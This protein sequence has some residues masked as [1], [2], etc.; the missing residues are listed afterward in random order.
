MASTLIVLAHFTVIVNT[1]TGRNLMTDLP[2]GVWQWKAG[3]AKSP[4]EFHLIA[5]DPGAMATGWAH[6]V[7]DY[8]AFSRPENKV[9]ANLKSWDCGQYTGPDHEQYTAAQMLVYRARYDWKHGGQRQA[10]EFNA[11]TEVVS[12]DFQLVQ[13]IG[14]KNL[15]APVRFNAVL[16]WE[17]G[18]LATR[19]FLQNRTDRLGQT[20]DRLQRMGFAGRWSATA[21]GSKDAFSAMQHGVTWLKKLKRESVSFPWKLSDSVGTNA[22]WDCTCADGSRVHDLTHP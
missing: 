9:L 11:R 2:K 13:T 8:R 17:C 5:F 7:V 12:E 18:K 19:F 15:L 21:K 3:M 6:F 14:G 4:N 20:G 22:Y 16:Q 1:E 10:H